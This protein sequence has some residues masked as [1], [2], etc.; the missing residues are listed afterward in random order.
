ML[1][2]NVLA[3]HPGEVWWWHVVA[4]TDTAPQG[5]GLGYAITGRVISTHLAYHVVVSCAL[6]LLV[7]HNTTPVR[8]SGM[9]IPSLVPSVVWYL[10]YRCPDTGG[11]HLL[12]SR[13]R[14]SHEGQCGARGAVWCGDVVDISSPQGSTGAAPRDMRTLYTVYSLLESTSLIP[15]RARGGNYVMCS[16]GM[17]TLCT[18]MYTLSGPLG[19]TLSTQ[20]L[21]GIWGAR[22]WV[23]LRCT[24]RCTCI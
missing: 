5:E 6:T 19:Y 17:Y 21:V 12:S 23:S 22:V 7:V 3:Y 16:P 1:C 10:R 11:G 2:P 24:L 18:T 15:T 9:D 4:N 13:Y 8:H 20:G 14:V